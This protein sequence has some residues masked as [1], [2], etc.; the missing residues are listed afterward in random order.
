APPSRATSPTLSLHD[1]LPICFNRQLEQIQRETTLQADTSV[2]IDQ[3]TL[4]DYG[5]Y[6]G[7]SYLT[8]EDVNRNTHVLR[9]YD[10]IGYT[11]LNR[12]EE[13]TSEL[14]SR[15]ELVCRLL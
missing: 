15:F 9:E 4:L 8:T 13:H 1:A 2:P 6:L 10:L 5:G 7:L 12:S 3:R 11:R 14:Q